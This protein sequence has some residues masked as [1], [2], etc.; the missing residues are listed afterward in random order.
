MQKEYTIVTNSLDG[1]KIKNVS[2]DDK[3]IANLRNRLNTLNQQADDKS[4]RYMIIDNET[5]LGIL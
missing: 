2:L 5:K 4:N 3:E 1:L